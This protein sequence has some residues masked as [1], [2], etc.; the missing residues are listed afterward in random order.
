MISN[1]WKEKRQVYWDR[2]TALIG[3]V[4]ASGLRSLSQPELREMAFLYRQIASDLSAVRQ[5]RTARTLQSD[6]NRLLAQAHAIIY[7]G[8][9]TSLRP[10]WKFFVVEYP[11]LFRRLLPFTLASLTVFLAGALLGAAITTA[12]PEFMRHLLGPTMVETIDRHEMWTHSV[13]SM[14]PQASSAIM[15]NNLGVIFAA[16]A[17]GITAGIG[18]LYMIGWNGILIGVVAAACHAAH[19]SI[20]LWSFVAPHGSLELP[21]IVISGGAGLRIAH[22]MLFPGVFR[23]RYSLFVA[24]RESVRLL[25]GVVPMLMVAGVIEGFFSPSAAAP[26]LK[27]AVGATLFSLLLVWLFSATSAKDGELTQTDDEAGAGAY[28]SARSLISR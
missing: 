22:G 18:T 17:A 6:L 23:R 25:A 14:A 12:R 11:R 16:F 19:M 7:S 24:G 10:V 26:V 20:S 13:N 21:A 8:R 27:F 5:D 1:R 9:K 3:V 28:T 4:N 2:M 15:T